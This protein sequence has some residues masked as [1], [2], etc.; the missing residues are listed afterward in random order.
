MK[1][2]LTFALSYVKILK[3]WEIMLRKKLVFTE[4]K[5]VYFLESENGKFGPFDEVDNSFNGFITRVHTEKGDKLGFVDQERG[6]IIPPTYESLN[7]DYDYYKHEIAGFT[8][9]QDNKLGYLDK[10]GKQII[11]A[12]YYTIGRAKNG[13]AVGQRDDERHAQQDETALYDWEK[14]IFIN[15]GFCDE[16]GN[17]T[18]PCKYY[19]VDRQNGLYIFQKEE[20]GKIGVLDENGKEIVPC[21][22]DRVIISKDFIIAKENDKFGLLDRTGKILTPIT[23]EDI[24][25]SKDGAELINEDGSRQ[26]C[27]KTGKIIEDIEKE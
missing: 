18:I 1:I 2:A 7:P 15:A 17:E 5:A 12:K 8:F 4:E 6:E 14:Q 16:N 19:A 26:H 22:Y 25:V 9:A 24:I 21:M 23:Y 20:K 3:M 11:P 10:D 27:D 13:F